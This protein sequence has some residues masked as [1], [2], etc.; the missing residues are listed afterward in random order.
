[1]FL[2]LTVLQNSASG[3]E[4]SV[5]LVAFLGPFFPSL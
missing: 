5:L 1:V 3:S 2:H 4:V